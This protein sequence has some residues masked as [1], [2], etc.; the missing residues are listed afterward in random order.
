MSGLTY[1]LTPFKQTG[2]LLLILMLFV[3]GV[4]LAFGMVASLG[5]TLVLYFIIGSA[6]FFIALPSNAALPQLEIPVI[7]LF[8]W[9]GGILLVAILSGLCYLRVSTF[10]AERRRLIKQ[11]RTL[12]SADAVTGFDNKSRLMYELEAQCSHARRY[13]R[14]FS[15]L[16]FKIHHYEQFRQLYGE[17]EQ[18]RLLHFISEKIF[19]HTRKSDMRFRV[20]DDTFAIILTDTPV[21]NVGIVQKKIDDDIRTFRLRNNKLVSISYEYGHSSFDES[22]EEFIEVYELAKEQVNRNVS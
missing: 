16:M 1:I 4:G 15:F 10:F 17:D 19:A 6:F 12:I 20:E 5:V 14:T 8:F 21:E 7:Y 9:M 3:I 22:I 18:R 13:G 11:I 2:L